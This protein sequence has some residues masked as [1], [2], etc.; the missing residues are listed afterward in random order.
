MGNVERGL[1]ED[2]LEVDVFGGEGEDHEGQR[3]RG[4]EALAHIVAV[5]VVRLAVGGTP[6]PH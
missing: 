1:V 5:G 3:R 6:K 4:V 2:G